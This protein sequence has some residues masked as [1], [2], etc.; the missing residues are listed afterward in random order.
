MI[1]YSWETL[2]DSTAGVNVWEVWMIEYSW[3][4]PGDINCWSSCLGREMTHDSSC[5]L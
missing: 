5:A 1:K 4:T 2:G 3:E